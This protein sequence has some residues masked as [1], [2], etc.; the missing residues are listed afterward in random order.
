MRYRCRFSPANSTPR[1]KW[2][3]EAS[4]HTARHRGIDLERNSP[5][6]CADP[7]WSLRM[8]FTIYD[9]SIPPLIR[10]LENLS[11][12]LDKAVAQA[13]AEDR[14][15]NTLLEARL[16]PDMFAFTR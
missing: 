15:L 7:K 1:F 14:D 9:A 11:R 3:E 6:T 8:S 10:G 16:A 5:F 2:P 4:G 13:K 12:I